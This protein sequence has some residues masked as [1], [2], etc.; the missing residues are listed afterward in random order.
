[1][2]RSAFYFDYCADS[3]LPAGKMLPFPGA[4]VVAWVM[5]SRGAGLRRSEGAF[6]VDLSHDQ[7]TTPL[8]S[9]PLIT[10]NMTVK[11]GINGYVRSTISFCPD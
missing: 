5:W 6:E 3:D 4:L 11:L 9:L 2:P 10:S 1:M 8:P 7:S